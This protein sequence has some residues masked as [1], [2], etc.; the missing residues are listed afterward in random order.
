VSEPERRVL[1]LIEQ[2]LKDRQDWGYVET[3]P[4]KDQA[5]RRIAML[6]EPTRLGLVWDLR[7]VKID[8]GSTVIE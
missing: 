8:E 1:Y 6:R 2:T 5:A 4:D 7:L 3:W